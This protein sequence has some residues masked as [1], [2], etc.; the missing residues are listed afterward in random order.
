MS[1]LTPV[2]ITPP[3]GVVVTESQI[4]SAGRW[5]GTDKIR[6][7]NGK[8]QKDGGWVLAAVTPT[9]GMPRTIH[10]W[11]DN[12]FN[13]YLAAG[14]YRKLYVYDTAWL[15]NDITPFRSTGTLGSNPFTTTSGSTS[16]EVTQ[17]AHG[18]SPG[19]TVIFTGATASNGVTLNG[20][21]IVQTVINANDYTVTA[22]TTATGS[23]AGGGGSV[24]YSYEISVG[25]ELGTFGYGYGVG[26]YGLG[27]Y[28]TARATST[29]S[30]EPRVW[31][32]DHF[33][34][35]LVAAYN[36]GTIYLFDPTASQPW[37]RAQVI[38]SDPALPANCRYAFV[39]QER[40]VFALCAGMVLQWCSQG[41]YTTW[42]PATANTAN[43]RTLSVGTK[44]V[45]G[46]VLG[47]QL[48]AIWSDAALYIC[49]YTGP[50]FIYTTMVAGQDC[51]L[52]SPNGV[53][54]VGGAAFWMG[55]NNFWMFNGSVMPMPRV[56]D[57][58][59]YVFDQINP[60][61]TYQVS[62]AYNPIYNEIIWH[63]TIGTNTSPTIYVRF[64]LNPADQCWSIGTNTR[65]SGTH[66]TQGD[67][68][69][70]FGDSTGFIYQHENTLDANGSPLAYTLTLAPYSVEQGM[71]NT[72]IESILWD[73]FE[74]SGTV[75]ALLNTYDRMTDTAPMDT[76]T[77]TVAPVAAGLTDCRISGRYLQF[78]LSDNELGSYIR[79]GVPT[80]FVRP[81]GVRP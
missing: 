48:A 44:L 64:H 11:R 63:I 74:Q 57:I 77:D 13:N 1:K 47:P 41:D 43:S 51:G 54:S 3:P 21:Y 80:A 15:Q 39:T 60:N 52:I 22:L 25:V 27:T 49:Q 33:G 5:V 46:V 29:I 28:G 67:N 4:A 61:T 76:E 7:V 14:T 16:V 18:V 12:N 68:R 10:A 40:F 6:F 56:E 31:S 19:D 35:F 45:A 70:Y 32:L 66:F 2:Q 23:G 78:T 72:Q 81:M 59:K 8:P 42:T 30:I 34:Q 26:G 58:R 53:V 69:P 37:G 65:T 9:S 17:T 50:P 62:A 36:T 75:T 20:T 38:S 71:Q 73:F 79:L 24:L 55:Q